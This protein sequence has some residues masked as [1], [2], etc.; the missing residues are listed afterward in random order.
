VKPGA[1][2]WAWIDQIGLEEFQ[3]LSI[4]PAS[5]GDVSVLNAL[6]RELAA[7]E[8]LPVS[9]S[10]ASLLRDGFGERPKFRV[11]IAEWDGQA[12][13][14]AFFFDYYSTFEGRAGIFLEDLYVRE[15]FRGRKIGNALLAR[16]AAIAREENC[17]GVRW[18]VLDWNTPA[19]EFYRKI[20]A[21]FL[22]EWKTVSLHGDALESLAEN[23]SQAAPRSTE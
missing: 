16:V 6:I 8:R 4:R 23:P 5:A 15:S 18:Q 7:F 3:M 1:E 2:V 21:E 19:I 20:G 13:G 10:D 17:F 9:V 12:A 22:H 14:Y 11:L